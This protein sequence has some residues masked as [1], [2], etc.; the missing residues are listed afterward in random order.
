MKHTIAQNKQLF[1]VKA[2]ANAK[3]YEALAEGEVGFYPVGSNT[4]L[5]ANAIY[6]DLPAEFK[7]VSKIN[8]QVLFSFDTIRKAQMRNYQAKVYVAP[9]VNIWEGVVKH[10]KCIKT[11]TFKVYLEED[12]LMRR[13]G[14]TWADADSTVA[15][16]PPALTCACDCNGEE[17]YDNNI[18]TKELIK[19][20]N[21]QDTPYYSASAKI[22]VAGLATGAAFPAGPVQGQLFLKTG[23]TAGVNIYDGTAWKVIANATGVVTDLDTLTAVNKVANTDENATNDGVLV[24]L[25][26]TGKPMSALPY[27]DLDINHVFPRGVRLTPSVSINGGEASVTFTETQN[28]GYEIGAGADLRAEEW[29]NMNYYTTLNHYP[30]LHDGIAAD[31]LVY[32]FENGKTYSTVDFEFYTDKTEKNNGDKRSFGV[33]L[34]SETPSVYNALKALLNA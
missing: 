5:A 20:I 28:I 32:Q 16:A 33:M 3:T 29:E 17:A 7:I 19:Q 23:A 15:T 13:D 14:A 18:M 1:N 10:C 8:G 4:S 21:S 31:G 6:A 11:A 22:V 34:A 12:A 30:Q 9:K 2:I 26:I 27:K 25:V 24:T